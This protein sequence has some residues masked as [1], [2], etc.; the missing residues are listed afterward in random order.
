MSLTISPIRAASGDVIG[1]S[2]IARDITAMKQAEREQ[3][4]LFAS[5]QAARAEVER[6]SGLKDD[7]LAVL[8][9]ELRTPLNAV[10]GYS[11]LL[12]EGILPPA[13][14]RTPSRRFAGTRRRRRDSW[15]RCSISRA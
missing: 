10:M 15:S 9:H 6:A 3:A 7:F 2:K 4:Q 5:E 8:S 1:A 12:I 14:A 13:R 11:Q